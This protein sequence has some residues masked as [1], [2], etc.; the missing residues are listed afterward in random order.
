MGSRNR[1]VKYTCPCC[2][3]TLKIKG[4]TGNIRCPY[5]DTST[6]IAVLKRE[7]ERAFRQS[8]REEEA[9]EVPRIPREEERGRLP[10]DAA[11]RADRYEVETEMPE[12]SGVASEDG[13]R[14]A[15]GAF[16][17][18]GSGM[19]E[20]ADN[21]RRGP[22]GSERRASARKR[23][24]P[25]KRSKAP[26]VL[27][28]LLVILLIV[29]I[30]V[31]GWDAKLRA[32]KARELAA[33]EAAEEAAVEEARARLHDVLTGT[34]IGMQGDGFALFADGTAE[35]FDCRE[36]AVL[37]GG[38][39]R[40][41]DD[42]R[43]VISGVLSD[44]DV[45][46][47]LKDTDGGLLFE[48]DSTLWSPERFVRVSDQAAG[49]ETEDWISLV[50]QELNTRIERKRE[51]FDVEVGGIRFTLPAY[52]LAA[53]QSDT[54]DAYVTADGG[55]VILI[56]SIGMEL[57]Q[58][59]AAVLRAAV[60]GDE[61]LSEEELSTI[62]ESLMGTFGGV[63]FLSG[64]NVERQSDPSSVAG[65]WAVHTLEHIPA[66]EPSEDA[67]DQEASDGSEETDEGTIRDWVTDAEDYYI[68]NTDSN[69]CVM[70]YLLT[71]SQ[72]D[73]L[74]RQDYEALIKNAVAVALSAAP[75]P[76]PEAEPE[77]EANGGASTA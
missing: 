15:V 76:A 69:R 66:E 50:E 47:S 32:D 20:S 51:P 13:G 42:E 59:E 61:R 1:I 62:N 46:A 10:G 16:P 12:A 33:A 27:G 48:S 72:T 11:D 5:C 57:G 30:V 17:R 40:I 63:N 23:E 73:E 70:V 8:L 53:Q 37:T 43:V 25:E 36:Q 68:I 45:R 7:S 60:V 35:R 56:G 65:F 74:Y 21:E 34:W 22:K 28:I 71:G 54:L 38:S 9:D 49:R 77:A 26:V 39:W 67:E 41:E 44:G 2:G 18:D 19:R 4:R 75:E 58:E 55:A 6:P 3:A 14:T 31:Y 24:N 64:D 29:L 52:Y